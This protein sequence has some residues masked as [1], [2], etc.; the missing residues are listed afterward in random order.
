MIHIW[1]QL[2]ERVGGLS[3][4]RCYRTQ[5]GRRWGVSNC[6]GRPIF[7]FFITEHWTCAM[8]RHHVEPNNI[9]L[10]RELP[11]DSDVRQWSHRLMILIHCLW[12]KSNNRARGQFK[13][14]L[15]WFCFCFDFVYSYARDG[16][17]SI[18]YLLFQVAQIK[19][20]NCKMSAK[21]VNNYK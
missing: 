2:W 1:R 13:C 17:W 3:K 14:Y 18:V 7:I 19:Q 10:T 15:A 9:L 11:F 20:V 21:N 8:T 16:C 6:S 12:A 5:E 4:M